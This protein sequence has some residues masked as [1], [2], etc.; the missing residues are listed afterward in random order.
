MTPHLTSSGSSAV[1][2]LVDTANTLISACMSVLVLVLSA[3]VT[4][5]YHDFGVH[6]MG[7]H[8]H[9]DQAQV[10]E[11]QSSTM[12]SRHVSSYRLERQTLSL[13]GGACLTPSQWREPQG[14]RRTDRPHQLAASFSWRSPTSSLSLRFSP[15]NRPTSASAEPSSPCE[16]CSLSEW[17]IF[18]CLSICTC[19]CDTRPVRSATRRCASPSAVSSEDLRAALPPRRYLSSSC[20]RTDIRWLSLSDLSNSIFNFSRLLRTSVSK[21]LIRA[22]CA[23]ARRRASLRSLVSCCS[24]TSRRSSST[25]RSCSMFASL[26]RARSPERLA[27]LPG[28]SGPV[29]SAAATRRCASFS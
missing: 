7:A 3:P 29:P 8:A 15:S 26:S 27:G 19:C 22:A 21:F 20:R 11:Y 13:S 23:S 16:S 5:S 25:R 17:I 1:V 14:A 6:T 2:I 24:T 4:R 9:D 12:A 28:P 18:S 10:V